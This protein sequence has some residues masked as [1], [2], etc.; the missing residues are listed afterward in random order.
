MYRELNPDSIIRTIRAIQERINEP[1]PCSG[2]SRVCGEL[3]CV[4]GDAKK[5]LSEAEQP[6]LGLR[7][8]VIALLVSGSGGLAFIIAM[9]WNA[10]A[11]EDSLYGIVQGLE[12]SMNIFVLVGAAVLFL[13]TL[14]S[15]HN[16]ARALKH[17]HELR[18]II[19]VIDM[20]QLTKYSS[21]DSTITTC[22]VSQER[23]LNLSEVSLYLRYSSDLLSLAAKIA[24]L[25]AQGVKDTSVIETTSD[26]QQL[27]TNL[28]NKIWQ[29]IEV[30]ERKITDNRLGQAS[31]NVA[32][33]AGS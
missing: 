16:R 12:A 31:I 1:F 30:V 7:S 23:R 9:I 17:L 20:H 2:L 32:H 33:V 25:Y 4:A 13:L 8:L 29:K 18:S 3:L 26:L 5:R 27:A 24:A 11:N 15:R 6:D 10:K 21:D 22:S 14:E 19:H 28:S